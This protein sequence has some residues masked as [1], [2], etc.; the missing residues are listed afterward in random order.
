MTSQWITTWQDLIGAEMARRGD[1]GPIIACTL[2]EAELLAKF[3]S[4]YGVPAGKPFLAWTADRVYFSIEYDGADG[5]E[6]APRNPP[7][8]PEEP[9]LNRT[10]P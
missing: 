1:P 7:A 3:D 5:C 2:T 10:Y 4:D 9:K 6:S 8:K